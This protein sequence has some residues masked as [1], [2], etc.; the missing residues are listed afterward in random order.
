MCAEIGRNYQVEVL[1]LHKIYTLLTSHPGI[2]RDV[3]DRFFRKA[4][5][6]RRFTII[7]TADSGWEVQEQQ[8]SRVVRQVHYTD[9]HRVERARNAFALEAAS[10][11][12]AGW[13][14][15]T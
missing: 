5:Q 15:A 6:T 8:N 3:Y 10:L 7:D 12:D 11:A 14:E 9:W 2:D 1:C 13:V 4:E